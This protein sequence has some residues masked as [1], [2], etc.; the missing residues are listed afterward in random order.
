MVE[1]EEDL[2]VVLEAVVLEGG[3]GSELAGTFAVESK[4]LETRIHLVHFGKKRK[5]KK[6]RRRRRG[7]EEEKKKK[8]KRRRI[9]QTG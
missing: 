7:E 2:E 5:K 3:K 8:R 4:L 1:V 9:G 6:K